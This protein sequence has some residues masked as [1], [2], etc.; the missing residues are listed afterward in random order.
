MKTPL[1]LYIHI[2]FCIRKCDYCDFL[3]FSSTREQ[4]KTYMKALKREIRASGTFPEHHVTTVFFGGGTPSVP[5]AE[6]VA[7]VLELLK[8]RFQFDQD[9]EITLEAN[10][11]TLSEEKLRVYREAGFNRL[12]LG[13]QS[14]HSEELKQLGRIH[15][16]KEFLESFSM[17][18][19]LGFSNI[20]VDL[21]SGL[22][23]QTLKSYE[24][25]L[26][27]IAKLEPEHIS[28]YSL[29]VEPGTPFAERNLDLPDEETERR[30]YDRTGEILGEYGYTQY[31]ISNYAKPGRECR[32][33]IGY[34]K[35]T[36]YLGFGP[37][38]AS[39]LGNRRFTNTTDMEKY[40]ADSGCPEMVREDV[41]VLSVQDCM[42][43]FMFL[44]LR[45]NE[46]ISEKQ[47]EELFGQRINEVYG[48]VLKKYL[49]L[50]LLW[51]SNGRIG[52][53]REGI[54]ISNVILSDFLLG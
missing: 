15:T 26:H 27:T 7:E 25:S 53:T 1:E 13:C 41:E 46:G 44:G 37:G 11:G 21:M 31:E 43:E 4:Q 6:R 19:K 16:Y 34:W 3:S 38:A 28:A 45:M 2:P 48:E 36:N 12:S 33:N 14:V 51:R 49:A 10:P 20:N 24:V 54:S 42:E 30:M 9:A 8:D 23:G 39:L 47:F 18:R 22:P 29:I 32:H 17:A 5:E 50:D 35:R 52:L 40:F